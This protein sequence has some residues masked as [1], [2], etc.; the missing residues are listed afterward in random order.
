MTDQ[1]AS[2][3]T[4]YTAVQNSATKQWEVIAQRWTEKGPDA[5]AKVMNT[6]DTQSGAELGAAMSQKSY[7]KIRR[8]VLREAAE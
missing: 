6:Y 7:D 3:W 4:V 5:T 8:N 2:I 1:S